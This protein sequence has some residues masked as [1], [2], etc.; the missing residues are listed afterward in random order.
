[1]GVARDDQDPDKGYGRLP[2]LIVAGRLTG[3]LN[4]RPVV[5]EA[6]DRGLLI[7]LSSIRSAWVVRRTAQACDWL[8]EWLARSRIG[9]RLSIAGLMTVEIAPSPSGL[10]RLFLSGLEKRRE[11]DRTSAH[12]PW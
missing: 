3:T 7:R 9:V 1:M 8:W 5:I 4:G 12:H 10:V 2:K 6:D 11:G